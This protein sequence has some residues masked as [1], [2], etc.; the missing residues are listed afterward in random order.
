[1]RA[2]DSFFVASG[3]LHG[4]EALEAGTLVDVF[5]PAREDFLSR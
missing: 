5:T 2:G 1:L 3:L 4:V